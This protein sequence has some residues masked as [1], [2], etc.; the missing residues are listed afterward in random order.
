MVHVKACYLD[1]KRFTLKRKK[2]DPFDTNVSEEMAQEDVAHLI[3]D[4][5]NEILDIDIES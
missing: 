2:I 3:L 4:E 1:C 5:D